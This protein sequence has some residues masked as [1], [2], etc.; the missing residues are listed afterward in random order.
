MK[1]R[2]RLVSAC[3]LACGVAIAACGAR[4]ELTATDGARDA[5][6]AAPTCAAE[7]RGTWRLT[8]AA[9]TTG[10][11]ALF[12]GSG[13]CNGT[14]DSFLLVLD[15]ADSCSRNGDYVIETQTGSALTGSSDNLGGSAAAACGDPGDETLTFTMTRRACDAL[16]YDVSVQDSRAGSPFSF[17]AVMTRCRCDIGWKPC[18]D[19]LPPD[20]CAP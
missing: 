12:D 11:L 1:R 7:T 20:M 4:T 2:A 9:G 19:P 13:T 8:T 6:S 3:L 17:D 14:P 18:D 15:T 16:T 5:C 10:H